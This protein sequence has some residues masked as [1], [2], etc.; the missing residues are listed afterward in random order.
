VSLLRLT[1]AMLGTKIM[2]AGTIHA[3]ICAA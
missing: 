1:P 3:I 2:A